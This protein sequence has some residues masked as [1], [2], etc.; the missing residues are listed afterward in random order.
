MKIQTCTSIFSKI[1]FS[2]IYIIIFFLLIISRFE[3]E[4]SNTFSLFLHTYFYL[5]RSLISI[6]RILII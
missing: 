2:N 3:Y 5:L 1:H 6:E 4:K